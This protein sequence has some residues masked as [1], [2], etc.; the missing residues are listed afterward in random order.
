MTEPQNDPTKDLKLYPIMRDPRTRFRVEIKT[1]DGVLL[2]L[3]EV[4]LM[5][6]YSAC[7][8]VLRDHPGDAGLQ[9]RLTNAMKDFG[10]SGSAGGGHDISIYGEFPRIKTGVKQT[11]PRRMT[12]F[13]PWDRAENLDEWDKVGD[14]TV[15]SFC[16]SLHPD[17]VLELVREHGPWVI[18][19]TTKSYKWYL[20]REGIINAGFGGLKYYRH[21]DTEAFLESLRILMQPQQPPKEGE[22]K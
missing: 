1:P 19:C 18:E 9:E 7:Q 16:G 8:D 11:C 3:S 12:E 6:A 15:C 2:E 13:G 20:R 17:R 21:H 10:V 5:T 14:D 22:G 4:G